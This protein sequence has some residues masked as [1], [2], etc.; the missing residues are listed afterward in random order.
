MC[1]EAD[2]LLSHHHLI[3]Q[4]TPTME[5]RDF[6]PAPKKHRRARSGARTEVGSL[7]DPSDADLV[8]P[9]PTESTPDLRV[10][11]STL[12]MPSPLTSRD[13]ESNGT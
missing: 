4:S 13:Q 7:K 3:R 6:L 1:H 12:P 8:A 10:G 11:T 5:W 9:R 2:H